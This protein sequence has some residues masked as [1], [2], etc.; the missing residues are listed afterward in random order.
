MGQFGQHRPWLVIASRLR[1]GKLGSQKPNFVCAA[2]D[3]RVARTP[4]NDGTLGVTSRLAQNCTV[5]PMHEQLTFRPDSERG[6]CNRNRQIW[7]RS[8]SLF[9]Y[10][11]LRKA[12]ISWLFPLSVRVWTSGNRGGG[13]GHP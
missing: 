11:R 7:R 2:L 4:R 9:N 8:A 5:R 13:I 12:L 6:F 3:C 10:V 1:H